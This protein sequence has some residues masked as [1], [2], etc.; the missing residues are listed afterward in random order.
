MYELTLNEEHDHLP[1]DTFLYEQ[2][3]NGTYAME[4]FIKTAAV[5]IGADIHITSERCTRESPFNKI[6]S[7]TQKV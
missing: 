4:L 3:K 2:S 7:T 6:A 1:W 5:I